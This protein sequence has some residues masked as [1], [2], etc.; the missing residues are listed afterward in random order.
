MA[1]SHYSATSLKH[2][3][4]CDVLKWTTWPHPICINAALNG[5]SNNRNGIYYISH[6]SKV[7]SLSL[8]QSMF[9]CSDNKKLMNHAWLYTWKGLWS[10]K[11]STLFHILPTC[12]VDH[13]G[14]SLK[15]SFVYRRYHKIFTFLFFLGSSISTWSI[16]TKHGIKY[17][18]LYT[19]RKDTFT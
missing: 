8:M 2:R 19:Q 4:M 3:Q 16:Y 6:K 18:W 7:S 11:S 17:D 13:L 5:N 10:Q 12:I 15:W 9:N 1:P 14:R